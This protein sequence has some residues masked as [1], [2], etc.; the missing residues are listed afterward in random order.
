[1]RRAPSTESASLNQAVDGAVGR[2][3]LLVIDD[4]RRLNPSLLAEL[5]VI[6]LDD[7]HGATVGK[8]D[9]VALAD[10]LRVP[11]HDSNY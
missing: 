1:L 11:T 8:P 10:G 6:D 5:V 2:I 3:D 4:D 7:V 9:R